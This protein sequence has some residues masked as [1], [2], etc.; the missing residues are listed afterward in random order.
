MNKQNRL[1][2][3]ETVIIG[4]GQAGLSVGY[5]LA[6]RN[7]RFVILDA[8]QR[9]GDSWRNRWDSLRLFTP[10]RYDGLAGMPFPAP[11]HSFPTKEQM[12]DYLESYATRL[13][14]PVKTGVQVNGLTRHGRKYLVTTRDQI[15]EAAHVVV[16]M[17]RYQQPRVPRF[18]PQLDPAIVQLHSSEYRNPKQLRDGGVLI[19][20]AGNSG[21]EIGVEV[22][23][24]HRTW[25]SGRD[26][27]HIPFRINGLAA[28]L[29]LQDLIFRVVFHRVMTNHTPM[30]RKM[31]RTALSQG[32]PLIRTKPKDLAAA[33]I[34]RVPKVAGT[35]VGLPLLEDGRVLDVA[36]VI[37]CTG[38]N[39]GFSWIDLPV[40]EEDGVPK[41]ESGVVIGEP[42][43]YFVGLPFIYAF[44]STMIHGVGR[45]AE[46]IAQVINAR[47]RAL[48][49]ESPEL[50]A[51][52][53]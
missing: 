31:R 38:F 53:A 5:Y 3:I 46:R 30:G 17:A 8:S 52:P 11:P 40:F 23:R 33:G 41:H 7:L 51:M 20:G 4:A 28:R 48:A 18:A 10:A 37:W 1:E 43:L 19:V 29:F 50:H 26:T 22:A 6:R 47:S 32:A 9:I 36:N 39:P 49:A 34:Q 25:I 45:D 15:Y 35:R 21:A 27:G 2:Q 44:S 14:L 42:G 13:R 24:N 12:A 16:A